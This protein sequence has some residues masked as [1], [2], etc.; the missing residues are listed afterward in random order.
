MAALRYAGT[1]LDRRDDDELQVIR[2]FFA[3]RDEDWIVPIAYAAGRALGRSSN[4]ATV[5]ER[6]PSIHNRLHRP[7]GR[8]PDD[9]LQFLRAADEASDLGPAAALLLDVFPSGSAANSDLRMLLGH[10]ASWRAAIERLLS[11]NGAPAHSTG[12]PPE[13]RP[14]I[15][16]DDL[17]KDRWGGSPERDGRRLEA[18]LDEVDGDVFFVNLTVQS[19]DGSRLRPPV[20]FHLHDTFSRKTI[21]IRRI[22]EDGRAVLEGVS[23]YGVFTV[24][25][26]VKTAKGKWTGLEYDLAQ[27]RGLPR[28]FL[29]R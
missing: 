20:V 6:V 27:L 2:R 15:H 9:V 4:I 25:V 28:R 8:M 14:V 29:R 17:Q 12:R 21:H 13:P 1:L 19:T 16:R 23:A 26:Q 18:E 11:T 5:A 24:G 7:K 22:R 3:A 10:H